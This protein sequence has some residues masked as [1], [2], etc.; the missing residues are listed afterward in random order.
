[1]L[2][3]LA[4]LHLPLTFHVGVPRGAVHCVECGV[5]Q[6]KLSHSGP[7]T[8]HA[9]TYENPKHIVNVCEMCHS[10]QAMAPSATTVF[11]APDV[12]AVPVP[13]PPTRS[14][15]ARA[16][17]PSPRRSAVDSQVAQRST[18]NDYEVACPAQPQVYEEQK[19]Q[20]A[21]APSPRRSA[22]ELQGAQQAPINDYEV[23]CPAQPQV[24]EE[25]KMRQAC[26]ASNRTRNDYEVAAVLPERV[27]GV[28]GY[29]WVC[30]E[31]P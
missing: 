27:P 24:Y 23:P 18:I 7:W 16:P 19:T 5:P 13:G 31:D 1:M 3:V 9:C 12:F 2:R 20:Q 22:V 30:P 29:A 6:A 26:E 8:C 4:T 11:A 25:Q 28:D 21:P 10:P 15:Q 14:G 17:A